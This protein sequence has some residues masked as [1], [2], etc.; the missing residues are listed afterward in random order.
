VKLGDSFGPSWS[1]HWFR[2]EIALPFSSIPI[3]FR[4][5]SG[6]EALLLNEKGEPLQG[7]TGGD[8][9][10]RRHVYPLKPHQLQQE[11]GVLVLFVE[12][13]GNGLFGA[14][15]DGSLILPPNPD[16]TYTLK[17]CDIALFEH[18]AYDLWMD[19]TII[20]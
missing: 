3:H 15:R 4:W 16:R 18:E 1:T 10:D 12:M 13:A 11:G 20:T 19:F 14:G 9:G 8:G 7:L 5:D 6:S 2:V 17:R